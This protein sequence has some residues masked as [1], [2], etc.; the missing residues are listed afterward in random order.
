[1]LTIICSIAISLLPGESGEINKSLF[2][3]NNLISLNIRPSYNP[4]SIQRGAKKVSSGFW[5]VSGLWRFF[6]INYRFFF[7][8]LIAAINC[9]FLIKK[10]VLNK[11]PFCS[12]FIVSAE[13]LSEKLL[14]PFQ[15]SVQKDLLC[16]ASPASNTLWYSMRRY[17]KRL[18]LIQM[19]FK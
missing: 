16:W 7:I 6:F 15:T 17:F 1:M 2:H 19:I 9:R 4:H 13:N 12:S 10:F 18:S 3:E 11:K 5:V 8:S 14:F